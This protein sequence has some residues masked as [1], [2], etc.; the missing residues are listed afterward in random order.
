M[1]LKKE[2]KPQEDESYSPKLIMIRIEKVLLEQ[3][4][5][6]LKSNKLKRINE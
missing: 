5:P 3:K 2:T 6:H 4:K 1:T